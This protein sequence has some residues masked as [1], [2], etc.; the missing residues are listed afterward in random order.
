MG[1][2]TRGALVRFPAIGCRFFQQ[3]RCLYEERLNPGFHT[4]WRCLV[5]ARWESVYDDF[6]DRAENFGLSEAELGVLWGR[7]FERL[8]EESV[9]CPDLLA[10]EG[11]SMP[12]CRHLLEDICLLRLPACAGQCERFR[13][14]D[15]D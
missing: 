15:N 6:L 5:L 11:E 8:A 10:G 1:D 9:P 7:R 3:G 12:E 2:A 13:L 4:A 14:R